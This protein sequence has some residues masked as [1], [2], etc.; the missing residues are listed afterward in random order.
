MNAE[1]C[2]SIFK[3]YN[4]YIMITLNKLKAVAEFHSVTGAVADTTTSTAAGTHANF[5]VICAKKNPL[6]LIGVLT[7]RL[8]MLDR[9]L[10]P[11]STQ[12]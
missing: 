10:G 12:A 3:T 2:L 7:H 1:K 4:A 5:S 6:A 11:P 8:C 9:S